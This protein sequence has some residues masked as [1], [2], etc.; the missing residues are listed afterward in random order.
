MP[1]L[2]L[3]ANKVA[4]FANFAVLHVFVLPANAANT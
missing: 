3:V 2:T 1:L 4:S